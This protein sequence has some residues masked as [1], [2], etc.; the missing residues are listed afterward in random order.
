MDP[1]VRRSP[2]EGNG[3]PLPC[4]GLEN[5]MDCIVRGVAERWTRPSLLLSGVQCTQQLQAE[6]SGRLCFLKLVCPHAEWPVSIQFLCPPPPNSA[7]LLRYSIYPAI[8]QFLINVFTHHCSRFMLPKRNPV[9]LS[10]RPSGLPP[11]SGQPL[12]CLL[13]LEI[14]L[15]DT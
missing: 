12:F 5:S 2:G 3:Y 10:H 9:P 13:T 7:G 6:P 15:L 1:S 14:T 11:S 4:S 8:H